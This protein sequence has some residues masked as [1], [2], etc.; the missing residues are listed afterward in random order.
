MNA[1]L[2]AANHLAMAAAIPSSAIYGVFR[3]VEAKERATGAQ[4]HKL[5]VGEPFF[6]PPDEVADAFADALRRGDTRYAS[7]EGLLELREALVAKLESD[8]GVDTAVSRIFV[9]PGSCQGLSAL[10]LSLAEPGAEI[11]LPELHWPVHVQQSLLAGFR[12]VFYPLD[13][14][15]RPH[16]DGIRAVAGPRTRV[17]L[18][19]SPANP[20]G[21]VLDDE[22][23]RTLLDLARQRGWQVVSDEAYE[24]Y[25]YDGA[26][27]SVASLERDVPLAERIVHSVYSF[28]KSAAMTGYRLGYVVAATE[29]AADA[30]RLVQEASIIAPCTPV[31]HAGMAAL[32]ARAAIAGRNH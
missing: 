8:N 6:R 10:L 25:V 17:M 14:G 2:K 16:P 18:L 32:R 11:L 26:H 21:A 31:Q 22:L 5:H 1:H 27:V 23:A 3:E 7:M 12:P 15:F 20:S 19:N 4:V 30:L 9:S 24:H 28:S 29:Q 13:S